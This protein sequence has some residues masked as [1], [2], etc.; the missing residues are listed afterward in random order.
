MGY[1]EVVKQSQIDIVSK[2]QELH[3]FEHLPHTYP[4]ELLPL[5]A[6]ESATDQGL[7]I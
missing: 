7:L 4:L 2:T 5:M 1:S 3:S 6:L